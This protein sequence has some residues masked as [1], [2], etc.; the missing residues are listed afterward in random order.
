MEQT[1]IVPTKGTGKWTA[2]VSA[3]FT[4]FV[5]QFKKAKRRRKLQAMETKLSHRENPA[6]SKLLRRFHKAKFGGDSA[7]TGLAEARAWYA[8]LSEPAFR[9]GESSKRR[10][11]Q[12][13]LS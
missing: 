4:R 1:V 10:G 6:G 12:L 2:A 11:Q 9:Q 7:H 3:G 13:E 8:R 5:N